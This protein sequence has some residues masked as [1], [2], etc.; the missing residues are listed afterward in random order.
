MTP[1]AG[2]IIM[3]RFT[4]AVILSLLLCSIMVSSLRIRSAVAAEPVYIRADGSVDPPTAP[5]SIMGNVTYTLTGNITS[6]DVGIMAVWSSGNNIS[7]NTVMR[8]LIK[9]IQLWLSCN[10]NVVS[11]NNMSSNGWAYNLIIYQSSG[12]IVSGNY[13][14]NSQTAA[15]YVLSSMGNVI[16][17]ND[18][19]GIWQSGQWK[20]GAIVL[21]EAMSTLIIGNN[22]RLNSVDGI[23]LFGA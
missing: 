11:G 10:G 3:K 22:I 4:S 21:D 8:N 15:V 2:V 9:G 16:S 14:R 19:E 6:N 1:D 20:Y 5:I 23:S 18:I 12:N 13:I 17:G 7:Q